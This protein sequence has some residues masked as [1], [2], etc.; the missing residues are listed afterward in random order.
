MG[1]KDIRHSG[2]FGLVV[3]RSA[4]AVGV[5]VAHPRMGHARVLQRAGY[6]PRSALFRRHH[7][8]RRIRGHGKAQNLAKDCRATR[9]RV[10]IILEHEHASAL[11]LYHA[12]PGGRKRAARILGHDAQA[13]PCLDPSETQHRFRPAR[14]HRGAKAGADHLKRLP[15]GV[16]G[17]G[18]GGCNGKTWPLDVEFHADMA[19]R[20]IVHQLGH[21]ERMHP[22]LALFIDGAV[23]V[24]LRVQPTAGIA[25]HNARSIGKIAREHQ[26]GLG[27]GLARG[28]KGELCEP[29]IQRQLLAIEHLLRV[30]ILDLPS[31]PDGQPLDIAELQIRDAAASLAHGLI[32]AGN[33]LPERIDRPRPGDDDPVHVFCSAISFSMPSTIL[34]TEEM[35]KSDSVGSL[36]L[37]GTEMSNRSSMAKIDSTSPRES[38]PSSSGVL[39]I[40]TSET[41]S[42]AWSAMISTTCFLTSIAPASHFSELTSI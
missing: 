13:F 17:A 9:P 12:V 27:D 40:D 20:G 11:A 41:S 8:I 3:G 14:D 39:S 10:F 6:G 15:H 2:A 30:E 28:Q 1:A 37:K 23:I 5:D 19:G 7:D 25:E 24:I 18:T 26:S 36:A 42:I 35:S 4:G 21:H 34:A 32:G 29:V 31:N 38:I 22:V 16:I 33:I